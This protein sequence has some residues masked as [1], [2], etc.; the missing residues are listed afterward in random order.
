MRQ[1]HPV[2]DLDKGQF[3]QVKRQ[4]RR[5]LRLMANES[6]TISTTALGL[7]RKENYDYAM[8][9]VESYAV[10]VWD[11]GTDPTATVG[12]ALEPTDFV[13]LT[14]KRE[15]QNFRA[16]RRDGVDSTLRIQYGM[17]VEVE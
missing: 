16:I 14:T 10:R 1:A 11:D 4:V 8:V 17:Y 7:T 6:L 5:E 3:V 12:I 13:E 9:V 2:G 15:V